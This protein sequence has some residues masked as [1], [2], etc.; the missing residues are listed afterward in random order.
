MRKTS[1]KLKQ[2]KEEI[3]MNKTILIG[4]TTKEAELRYT[5][6]GKAVASVDLAVNRDYV[7]EGQEREADFI[8]LVIWGKRAETFANF[9]K[10]G[11]QVGVE[12]A[13]RTRNYDGQDGKKVY[14]TEVLVDNF[15][16]LEKKS[17]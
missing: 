15:T 5:P 2:R 9:V 6:N 8:R 16:F 7:A 13:L 14:V 11:H 4:R 17:A 10:K 12:G 1:N 3:I